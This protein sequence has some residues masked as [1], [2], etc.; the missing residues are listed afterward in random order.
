MGAKQSA[1]KPI[2]SQTLCRSVVLSQGLWT[3]LAELMEPVAFLQL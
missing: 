1:K 2:V 3:E